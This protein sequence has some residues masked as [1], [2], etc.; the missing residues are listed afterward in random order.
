MRAFWEEKNVKVV[1]LLQFK[2]LEGLSI[3]F[4]TFEVKVQIG[5]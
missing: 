4:E 5:G 1:K 3:K 2:S